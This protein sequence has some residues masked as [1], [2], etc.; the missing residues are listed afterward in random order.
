[1]I[2]VETEKQI[3]LTDVQNIETFFTIL[4]CFCEATAS[5]PRQYNLRSVC[6]ICGTPLD[7]QDERLALSVLAEL[8]AVACGVLAAVHRVPLVDRLQHLCGADSNIS[9]FIVTSFQ[10][11][12]H[13]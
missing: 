12:Q 1:M 4:Q 10:H 3:N 5:S 6:W 7:L 11:R 13:D 9:T 8:V 2:V